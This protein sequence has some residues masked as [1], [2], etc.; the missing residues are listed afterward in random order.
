M[1]E[2]IE[3]IREAIRWHKD[4]IEAYRALGRIRIVKHEMEPFILFNYTEEAAFQGGWNAVECISRGIIFNYQTAELVALPFPKFFNLEEQ[5]DTSLPNLPPEPCEVTSKMDGS[6]GILY[7]CSDGQPAIATRGSFT[8]PQAQWATAFLRERFDLASLDRDITLLFEIIYPENRVVL[9]YGITEALVLIGARN[10]SNEFDYRYHAM[11][12]FGLLYGLTVV[13]FIGQAKIHEI[14]PFMSAIMGVE[15]WVA[16][17]SEGLR[18]KIKTDEYRRLH[19]LVALL[20]PK[21]VRDLL[22]QEGEAWSEFLR[23]LPDEFYKEATALA[24]QILRQVGQKEAMIKA[25]FESIKHLAGVSRKAYALEVL[26][27]YKDMSAYLFALLDGH[28]LRTM[29][30]KDLVLEEMTFL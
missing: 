23:L 3:T 10:M 29:L 30:L 20:S 15:G 18:V 13:P 28:T 1:H 9:D 7:W 21:H 11:R 12:H 16:R 4:D 5:P 14:A 8:S 25:A 17:F 6:L 27:R 2:G 26:A 24:E 19:R 22:M